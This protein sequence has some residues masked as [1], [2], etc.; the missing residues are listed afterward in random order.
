M[1]TIRLVPFATAL[2]AIL[3]WASTG[4]AFEDAPPKDEALEGLT[5]ALEKAEKG[6]TPGPRPRSPRA[7]AASLPKTRRSIACSKN[8]AR[9][10]RLPPPPTSPPARPNLPTNRP[11]PSPT[12]PTPTS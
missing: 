5:E 10:P 3:A 8:W 1:G 7:R 11:L 6:E 9:R 4:L 2:V 12:S